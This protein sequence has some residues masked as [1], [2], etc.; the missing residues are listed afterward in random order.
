M[1]AG[2]EQFGVVNT[3]FR[4][5]DMNP[6]KIKDNPGCLKNAEGENS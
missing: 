2:E 6:E 3:E 1:E 4:V 5:N